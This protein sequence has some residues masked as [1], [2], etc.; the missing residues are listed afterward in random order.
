MINTQWWRE[1]TFSRQGVRSDPGRGTENFFLLNC[2]VGLEF[3][4]LWLFFKC[5]CYE[6][7]TFQ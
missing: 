5:M 6:Q 2:V 1:V 4:I 3:L 7:Y